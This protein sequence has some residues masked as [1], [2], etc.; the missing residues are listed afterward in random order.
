MTKNPLQF[1]LLADAHG[2]AVL[3]KA[4]VQSRREFMFVTV[5]DFHDRYS[6]IWIHQPPCLGLIFQWNTRTIGTFRLSRQDIVIPPPRVLVIPWLTGGYILIIFADDGQIPL[7]GTDTCQNNTYQYTVPVREIPSN[8][9]TQTDQP[10]C[11]FVHNDC[12][13][14]G[15]ILAQV[16]VDIVYLKWL[17]F[18]CCFTLSD[19]AAIKTD[20]C[21]V[22][23]V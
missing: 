22:T 9:C 7:A 21:W 19:L 14:W 11:V 18:T 5:P 17:P 16:N 15:R 1:A 10:V 6:R 13:Q 12:R 23:C 4:V 2:H 3:F 20:G 8:S